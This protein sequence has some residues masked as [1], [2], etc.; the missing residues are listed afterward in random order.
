MLPE[1]ALMRH[2]M[3]NQGIAY[4]R[5]VQGADELLTN[6]APLA[7]PERLLLRLVRWL[8][9]KRLREMIMLLPDDDV[10]EVLGVKGG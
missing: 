3:K 2:L 8:Y 7:W 1:Q 4:R 5:L 9:Q 10:D 6:N